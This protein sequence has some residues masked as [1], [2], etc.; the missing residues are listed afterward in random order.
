[1]CLKKVAIFCFYDKEGEVGREVFYLLEDLK[2]IVDFLIIVVNGKLKRKEV[3]SGLS[4]EIVIR[5]NEGFDAGAYKSIILDPKYRKVIENSQELI[6]C[7]SSFF[8]F[9]VPFSDI[10][11][12]MNKKKND[13]WGISCYDH[14]IM[15]HL[16]SYFLV[17]RKK[18]LCEKVFFEYFQSHIQ[19]KTKDYFSVC[20][21]F[22]N[23]LFHCLLN[24]GYQYDAYRKNIL[25][26]NYN[27]PYGSL[28]IDKLPI[29]KKKIFSKEFFLEKNVLDVLTYILKNYK[30]DINFILE[31]AKRVYGIS[32]DLNNIEKHKEEL[33]KADWS[34]ITGKKKRDSIKHFILEYEK[35]YIYGAGAEAKGVYM[36]FFSYENNKK[37]IG[38]IISDNQEKKEETICGYPIYKFREI[39]NIS[40]I[41]IIIAMNRKNSQEVKKSL[42]KVYPVIY[43][44]DEEK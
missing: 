22:E 16:Q 43:V 21:A 20:A 9:L 23:G 10:Y 12:L 38:F 30:Y 28:Y 3:F 37:L 11:T 1:M 41:G 2:K 8:G 33:V 42:D 35:I 39:N 27:N 14:G 18:I 15:L 25:C 29:V 26:D 31:Y 17:F 6:L 7:N 34:E 13:F 36:T 40:K 24:A 44:W 4:D 19:E 5:K 32:L